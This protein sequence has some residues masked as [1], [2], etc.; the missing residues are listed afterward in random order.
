MY[1]VCCSENNTLKCNLCL[2]LPDFEEV[3]KC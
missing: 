1:N 2:R 3:H